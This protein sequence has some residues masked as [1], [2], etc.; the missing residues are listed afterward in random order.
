VG[1]GAF[2]ALSYLEK[3][4]ES[5]ERERKKRKFALFPLPTVEIRFQ[6]PKPLGRG[7]ARVLSKIFF[8][9]ERIVYF[10]NT[11]HCYNTL[12][13]NSK[14]LSS[15]KLWRKIIVK[16]KYIRRC[17]ILLLKRVIVG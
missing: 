5:T 17:V 2:F 10:L 9:T 4:S 3:K 13:E 11:V 15:K 12:E 16:Y 8:L 1:A 6:S 7:K 14:L